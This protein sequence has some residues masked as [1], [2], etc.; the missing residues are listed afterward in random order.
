MKK[1]GSK[2]AVLIAA[3]VIVAPTIIATPVFAKD[4]DKPTNS[5]EKIMMETVEKRL[6]KEE[7]L[8]DMNRLVI[9]DNARVAGF[10][11]EEEA[12]EYL[13]KEFKKLGLA[14]EIEDFDLDGPISVGNGYLNI[15]GEQLFIKS[16]NGGEP[17]KDDFN[18]E[19]AYIGL[20]L[21]EDIEKAGNLDGKIALIERGSNTF[22]EK[23]ANAYNAGAEAVIIF[24]N[25][26]GAITASLGDNPPKIPV[27]G[28]SQ[29]NGRKIVGKLEKDETV[30]LTKE[31]FDID[32]EY[33]EDGESYNVIGKLKAAKNHKKA[34][35]IV[36]GAHFDS[37]S[38]P[39]ASDNAS[40]TAVIV[41]V[42][43]LLSN[44]DIRKNLNYNI[45]FVAFGG[46]E[47]GLLG[48]KEYV[49]ELQ[50]DGRVDEIEAMI[51]LDMVGVGDYINVFNL[52][53]DLS[54]NFS[55]LAEKHI[56]VGKGVYGGSYT[57]MSSSD[58]AP[59]E[60][61][62]IKSSLVQTAP[63][64]RYHTEND[65][66]EHIDDNNLYNVANVVARMIIDIQDSQY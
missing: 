11:G 45:E 51:N 36:L 62:G 16:F 37:V 10:D 7:M 13:A 42:A 46:E 6:S 38:S 28:M 14:S 2:I 24:N 33:H 19:I 35:T 63:D 32:I 58:H 52:K 54:S 53:N 44:K 23:A 47:L 18:G 40:G 27:L 59:F 21:P 26:A 50:E 48:S 61:V 5:N 41:E 4:H 22:A 3:G 1:R 31:N 66:M 57:N 12:A 64:P 60:E 43:R 55:K 30:N 15:Y 34:K 20:G 56:K 9:G 39:G 25:N 49:K 65:V 17:I 8:H 29:E